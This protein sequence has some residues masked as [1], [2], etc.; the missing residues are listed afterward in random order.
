MINCYKNFSLFHTKK[1]NQ[2]RRIL[3]RQSF[4]KGKGEKKLAAKVKEA[5][6]EFHFRSLEIRAARKVKPYAPYAYIIGIDARII[7]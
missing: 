2:K 1:I 6:D 4:G 5:G 3:S 7:G